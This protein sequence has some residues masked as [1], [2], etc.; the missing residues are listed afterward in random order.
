M[1]LFLVDGKPLIIMPGGMTHMHLTET[2]QTKDGKDHNHDAI[3]F[4]YNHQ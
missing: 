2:N 1:P 4:T 3:H